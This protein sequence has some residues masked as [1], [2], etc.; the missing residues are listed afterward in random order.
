[1]IPTTPPIIVF[2]DDLDTFASVEAMLLYFE[3]IDARGVR[4]VYDA[5][6]HRLVIRTDGVKSEGR[7]VGGGRAWVEQESSAA[8]VGALDAM[9]RS[10]LSSRF[11]EFGFD[12]D[13]VATMDHDGLIAA[14]MRLTSHG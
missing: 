3:P 14:A 6:G 8:V 1:M 2:S 9:L 13:T 4:A 7:W 11:R 10:E 5:E 12:E